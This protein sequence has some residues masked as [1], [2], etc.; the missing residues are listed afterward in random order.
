[1]ILQGDRIPFS[2]NNKFLEIDLNISWSQ[3]IEHISKSLNS[4]CFQMIILRNSILTKTCVMI[5]YAYFHS[6][7][8][9]GSNV[10]A[11]SIVKIQN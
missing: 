10:G 5:Y 9:Y 2:K 4:A 1:M 7:L 3:N 6:I 11:K 8:Q